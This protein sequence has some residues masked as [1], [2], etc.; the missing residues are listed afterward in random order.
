MKKEQI[1]IEL[2]CLENI[3]RFFLEM[4]FNKFFITLVFC[5]SKM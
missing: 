5:Y 4:N 3:I 2:S 1:Q